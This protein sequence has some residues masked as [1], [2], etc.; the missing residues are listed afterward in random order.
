MEKDVD[1]AR[2]KTDTRRS[3]QAVKPR[4]VKDLPRILREAKARLNGIR[5]DANELETDILKIEEIVED[6]MNNPATLEK[7]VA[8]Q[9]KRSKR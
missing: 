5:H 7:L 1:H 2:P 8:D 9:K 4:T 3:S 6:L